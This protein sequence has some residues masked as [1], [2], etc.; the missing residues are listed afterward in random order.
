[1]KFPLRQGVFCAAVVS[2]LGVLGTYAHAGQFDLGAN[3]GT[4]GYGPQ[5]GLTLAPNTLDMRVAANFLNYS[6]NTTSNG[7]KYDGH[8]KLRST[9]LLFDW[10]PF[11]G[12]FRLTAGAI[13]NGNKFDLT[14]QPQ[15]GQT[16]TLNG[17]SYTASTGDQVS[18]TVKF[19][20]TAPYLGIGWG[21]NSVKPG[22]HFTS[23]IGVMYQGKPKSSVSIHTTSSAAQPAAD[24]YAAQEEQKLNSDLKRFKWYPVVQLGVVYRF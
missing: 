9:A 13:F 12:M 2:G 15:A 21:D 6:Y 16:Y 10:H 5:L 19:P 17:V 8:L 1:M 7:I 3:V 11:S 24:Q 20:S 22:F 4:L 23:D 18:A 14:G